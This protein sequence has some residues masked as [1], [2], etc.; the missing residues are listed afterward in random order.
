MKVDSSLW[1]SPILSMYFNGNWKKK[2]NGWVLGPGVQFQLSCMILGMFL[3]L[4]DCSHVI[5]KEAMQP[6]STN[7]C[8]SSIPRTHIV[9]GNTDSCNCLLTSPLPAEARYKI[10]L[11]LS[12]SRLWATWH[13]FEEMKSG[14]PKEQSH[15]TCKVISLA[16]QTPFERNVSLL[17]TM[18]V[19]LR[20]HV[21]HNT[22]EEVRRHLQESVFP[23]T[24]W[25]LGIE[26]RL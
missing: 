14:S 16:Q 18:Y 2:C 10:L 22:H 5:V 25:I 8:L 12:C 23:P 1:E 13:G 15:L 20:M 7:C 24:T 9:E 6:V 26:F 4:Q 17:L 3:R 21:Y 11:N 19:C